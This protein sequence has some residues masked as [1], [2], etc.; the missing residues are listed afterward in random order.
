MTL[1]KEMQC[2]VI[3]FEKNFG[4]GHARNIG[5]SECRTTFALFCDSTN[6]I[7]PNFSTLALKHFKAS[8]ISAVFGRIANHHELTDALSRWRGRHLFRQNLHHRKDV[9][10]VQSLISYAVLFRKDAVLASG[11]FDRA[12]RKCEDQ[13]IGE[14]LIKSG[15]KI[16]SDPSL[17]AYSIR[18]ETM[19][20]LSI[21]F[22]RWFSDHQ[23]E[24][25][26][27]DAFF[28]TFRSSIKIFIR[29][30][31]RKKDFSLMIISLFLP[32]WL[33]ALSFFRKEKLSE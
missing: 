2:R 3:R 14:K 19:T 13:D 10:E 26:R 29:D 5:I 9:H 16:I 22:N 21:R 18:R 20:S 27:S 8:C 32:F 7:P 23:R 25:R 17:V 30:D 28:N 1:A 15:Y 24:F 33:L 11:N 6:I 31:F 4:R 12:L